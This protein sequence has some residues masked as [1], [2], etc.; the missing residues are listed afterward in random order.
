MTPKDYPT[1][2]EVSTAVETLKSWTA[3][4]NKKTP[5]ERYEAEMMFIVEWAIFITEG[6]EEYRR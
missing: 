1:E 5:L 4:V 6:L 2:D 3:I